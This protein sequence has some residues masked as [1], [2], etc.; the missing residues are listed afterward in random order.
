MSESGNIVAETAARI[1]ADLADPQTVNSARDGGWKSAALAGAGRRRADAGLGAGTARRRRRRPGR[2]VRRC[3]GS[4]A[5][6]RRRFR[7][8]KRCSPAG[9]SRAPGIAAP[10]GAMTVAPARPGDRIAL[11]ADGTLSGRAR[12][13][14]FAR[15]AG[16]I[17][18]LAH[19]RRRRPRSR[20]ST[21]A[22]A[23]WPTAATSPAT[24]RTTV[25]FD[26]V[27]PLRVAPA[28]AG[29]DQTALML[30]GAA[31]R[32]VET[33]GA[34]EAILALTRALCQRA[35]RLRAADRQVPGGAAQPGAARRRG[36]GR[37]DRGR[38][39]GRR[40]R[41]RRD[42]RRRGLP[43]GR[44]GEDPLR[45]GRRRRAP[46]SRIRCTAPS[47][48]PRSTSCTA[49]RCGCLSW[50]DDFGNESHWARGARQPGGGAR[51]R[52]ILAA[53]R[54]ALNVDEDPTPHRVR[55]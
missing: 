9:C 35:R 5:G 6:L 26:R 10:A 15:D 21:P 40:D 37:H 8:P 24:P 12:G 36:R 46:R 27:K 20:S 11:D 47:A 30:M 52:R 48:S 43:R 17:A 53:R 4:P 49:S 50:R 41:A 33:A 16:H 45:R 19:G 14:P 38:L 29:F 1:F 18:V 39:G 3:W 42:V 25:T 7:W 54:L 2:R 28:P 13:V 22:R 55:S 34:L 32:S 23:A 44:I 51:R 31:A